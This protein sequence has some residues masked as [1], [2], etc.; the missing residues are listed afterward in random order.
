MIKIEGTFLKHKVAR[1]LFLLF[2]VAALVPTSIL[3]VYSLVKTTN[4]TTES[5]QDN[6]RQDAKKLGLS[7]FERL[8]LADQQLKLH[9]NELSNDSHTRLLKIGNAFVSVY[10]I[11]HAAP[12]P[13]DLFTGQASSDFTFPNIT[14]PQYAFLN[15]GF[16]VLISEHNQNQPTKFYL[17]RTSQNGDRLIIG[18]VNNSFLWG[19]PDTHDESRGFCVYGEQQ[20]HIFC[21]QA[22]LESKLTDLSDQ[23]ERSPTGN[24]IWHSHNSD[25]KFY[26]GYWS[27]FLK[28]SYLYPKL[29]LV[30][31]ADS[32][33]ILK[34]VT[35]L[36]NTFLLIGLLT[37]VTI[38]LLSTIQIRKY[39]APLEALIL[40]IN[41]ISK[42]DFSTKI[43]VKSDDEFTKLAASFNLMSAKISQQFTFLQTLSEIDQQILSNSAALTDI[44][45]T[46]ISLANTAVESDTVHIAIPNDK[47]QTEF[48]VYSE[49]KNHIH[50][51]SNTTHHLSQEEIQF[52]IDKK[53]IR[54][55][56]GLANSAMLS[57]YLFNLLPENEQ[58]NYV[59]VPVL[60]HNKLSALLIFDF[61]KKSIT[62]ETLIQLREFGDRFAIALE[63]SEWEAQL[64][65]KA[66]HDPLTQLP[67][68]QLLQERLEQATKYAAREKY[69]FALMFVDLDR[70]KTVNDSLGHS[71]G[72]LLLQQ[73]SHRLVNIMRPEDTI[74]RV[75]GDEFVILL[76]TEHDIHDTA[77]TTNSLAH[78]I[79]ST[80]S[81]PFEIKNDAIK[82]EIR[83][84]ASIGV[85]I[86]P[87]DGDSAETLV[88]NADS[89]MYHAKAKGR[90]N[91]Q[92]YS[93]QLNKEA[94]EMLTIETDLHKAI[95]NNEFELYYQPKVACQSGEILGAEA[96]I[97]W[98]H[99]TKGLVSPF[100]F[101]PLA[102]ENGLIRYIGQ[103]TLEQACKQNQTWQNLGLPPIKVSVN[104]S[105]KQFHQQDLVKLVQET[106]DKTGLNPIYLD[107][108]IVE[109]AAMS[110]IDETIATVNQFREMGISVSIDDYGTGF[111]TLSYLKKFP[112][113]VLKIDREFIKN[114]ATDTGDQAIVASTVLL[115]HK[116]GLTV[117]AEGVEDD[118]QLA[119]LR[120]TACDEIQGYYFSPPVPASKFEQHLKMGFIKP[121]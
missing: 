43:E 47:R 102:E 109:S 84:G 108:E 104:L 30:V 17:A 26:I 20:T 48:T 99:P 74:S 78:E 15:S 27:L 101:I 87:T 6:L 73:V 38:S 68:R 39:L 49:D 25:Q 110:D 31:T 72:D 115:A 88:K 64:Y 118:Q 45:K 66:H 62:D 21:S 107:L 10:Q 61:G 46:T 113:N 23:F 29:T 65:Q 82:R 93:E 77:T 40:G 112:V 7:I 4:N 90:N 97:R 2:I 16:P 85:A 55:R 76:A 3:A 41:R 5:I 67:N 59:L 94:M 83:I 81:T 111:S 54:V 36:R 70:F 80:L 116:L 8:E 79:L 11:K 100:Y 69:S 95:E 114:L 60:L 32:K 89:A 57:A 96:L 19:Q 51:T 71:S 63:K 56:P 120:Q 42:N 91:V 9:L 28:P 13:I 86:Y 34:P 119:L 1:Q 44:I 14:K 121:E 37:I 53:T 58:P 22:A 98:N 92:F 50:G 33:E 12:I 52:L 106:I 35:S 105:P 75:G 103:W 117:V 24:T 18:L